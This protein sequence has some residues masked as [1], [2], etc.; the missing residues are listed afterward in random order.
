MIQHIFAYEHRIKIIL[1]K[2]SK[3]LID[4]EEEAIDFCYLIT[5]FDC[6]KIN[7]ILLHLD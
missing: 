2:A 4:M 3:F 6:H 7:I 1:K 5:D